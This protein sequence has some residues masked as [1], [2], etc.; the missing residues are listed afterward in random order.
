MIKILLSNINVKS[1][2]KTKK[3]S[4]ANGDNKNKEI[5]SSR[6]QIYFCGENC[7]RVLTKMSKHNLYDK[8][9]HNV[10]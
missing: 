7:H 3:R 8:S 9:E 6:Q 10:A 5:I 4:T 2:I 1:K